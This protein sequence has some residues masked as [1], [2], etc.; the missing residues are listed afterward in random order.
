MDIFRFIHSKDIRKYLQEINYQF[1]SLEAAWLIYQC[2]DATLKEKHK[3]WNELI[4]TMPDCRIEERRKGLAQE[5]LHGFL[6]KYMEIENRL[7]LEFYEDHHTDTYDSHKPFVYKFEYLYKDGSKFDWGTVFSRFD[8]IYES[9]ME[10]DEDVVSIHCTKMQ[11]DWP[12]SWQIADLTPSFD[13]LYLNSNFENQEEEDIYW[14]VFDS[15]WF[16]FPTPFQKGDI[17]WDPSRPKGFCGGPFVITGVC[18]DGIKSERVKESIRTRGDTSEMRVEGYFLNEDGSL[19]KE[20]TYNY[21]DLEFFENALTGTQRTLLALSS[22]LNGEIDLALFARAYHQIIT[23][24]YAADSVPRD[25][26][27]EGL[28]LAGLTKDD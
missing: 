19:Y 10:P 11:V 8:A 17:V 12:H 3:A 16:E 15:M 4:E 28:S 25:Y 23:A 22:F 24:G 5:S 26:T 6:K 1:N 27:R 9:I 20:V 7:E 21:M 18:L 2:R 14:D 13:L